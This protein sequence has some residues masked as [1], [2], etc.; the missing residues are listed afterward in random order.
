M[1]PKDM[2]INDIF[3]HLLKDPLGLRGSDIQVFLERANCIGV[4][5]KPFLAWC[6]DRYGDKK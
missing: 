3:I 5:L 4:D 2:L 1:H 6:K